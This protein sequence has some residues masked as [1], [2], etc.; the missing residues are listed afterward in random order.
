MD[1]FFVGASEV[2]YS[3]NESIDVGGVFCRLKSGYVGLFSGQERSKR[4][5]FIYKPGDLF[6][7]TM[8][9]NIFP[10]RPYSYRALSR[11]TLETAPVGGYDGK[12]FSRKALIE[13]LDY[14]Q[15]ILQM[16]F[17]RIDNLQKHQVQRRLLERLYFSAKRLGVKKG[18]RVSIDVPMSHVD[19]A[20]SIGT[21]RETVNRLMKQLE[22]CQ[23]LKVRRHRIT[24]MSFKKLEAALHA[25]RIPEG[26]SR[27]PLPIIALQAGIACGAVL[28]L[29][30]RMS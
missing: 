23:I 14:M 9:S 18:D 17:E 28:G 11:V 29:L 20:S 30:Q 10:K 26:P 4:L 5:L 19:L 21:S 16:Q 7:F 2:E 1:E 13:A 22:A 6:P 8:H 24:I 12:H 3:R 15:S 27:Q 25:K